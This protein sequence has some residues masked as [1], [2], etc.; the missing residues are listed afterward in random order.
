MKSTFKEV[1]LNERPREKAINNG[2]HTLSNEEL[3]ALILTSE[4]N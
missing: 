3:L 2:I 4:S 1:P